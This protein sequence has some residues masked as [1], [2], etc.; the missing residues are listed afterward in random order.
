MLY[1]GQKHPAQQIFLERG[2]GFLTCRFWLSNTPPLPLL[3]ERHNLN[4]SYLKEVTREA[5]G[6]LDR[7]DHVR[8]G[9]S[10][11]SLNGLIH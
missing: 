1:A 3:L 2:L 9:G 7:K 5:R 10:T 8:R 4:T 6:Y 11:Y